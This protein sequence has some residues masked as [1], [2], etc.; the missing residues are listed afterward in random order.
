LQDETLAKK[1]ITKGFWVYFF[2]L[3]TA[4]IGYILRMLVSNTLTVTEV[5]IFY[6]VLGLVGLVATYNDLGLTEALQYFIP[7]HRIKGEKA[8]VRLTIIA[9]FL[10]QMVTGILIFCLLYFGAEWLS[11]VHFHDTGAIGV[12][13]ILAF[14]FLGYN[15]IQLCST[16]F[17]AF[18]DTFAQGLTS[19]IQ[20]FF[21][22]IFTVVFRLTASLTLTSY[23][24]V[25][26]IGVAAAIVVGVGFLI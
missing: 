12:L 25:R 18:Q 3:F 8:K 11:T 15:I 16:I 22:L 13:R 6:S 20:Q 9:S 5:G 23:S 4:P 10:M 26:M 2:T 19:F 7:K 14:Y 24:I 1:L 21:N 17:V